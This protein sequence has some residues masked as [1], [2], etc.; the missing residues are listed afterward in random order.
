MAKYLDNEGLTYFWGK[1]KAWVNNKLSAIKQLPE[2]PSSGSGQYLK[3]DGTDAAWV[4]DSGG[5]TWYGTCST[6]AA[7]AAKLVTCP[8][9]ELKEGARIVVNFTNPS[10]V[11]SAAVTMNVNSTGAKTVYTYKTTTA[12]PAATS[13]TNLW[14]GNKIQTFIYTGSYW[15]TTNNPIFSPAPNASWGQAVKD[16]TPPIYLPKEQSNG[17]C[18]IIETDTP[19]GGKWMVGNY[20]TENLEFIY[21]S[22]SIV[23]SANAGNVV[24]PG[25]IILPFSTDLTNYIMLNTSAP[26][27]V[28]TLSS[29]MTVN[30]GYTVTA[31]FASW[32]KVAHI[33]LS[34][35]NT[36]AIS[37]PANGNVTNLQIG[38]LVSGKR[39][40][41]HT[42]FKS[43]G[44]GGG[45]CFGSIY[46][47]GNIEIGAFDSRNAAYTIPA[48]SSFYVYST[49]L[50]A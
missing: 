14:V 38:T 40:I 26:T 19:S 24:N 31:S 39:P 1:A 33:Y 27:V 30:S 21:Y 35:K 7:T 6:A 48:N 10:K 12:A 13:S 28:T 29:I 15:V 4:T 45:A 43:N 17:Y 32:G 50:L 34:I 42:G 36:N 5:K 18:P 8:G 25:R 49:Y 37:V 2:N 47:T 9:F 3:Y 23:D 41:I 11:T 20:N 22:S 46:S 16:G 44:D